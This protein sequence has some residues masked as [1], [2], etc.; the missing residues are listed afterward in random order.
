M[1][2]RIFIASV[3]LAAVS[4]LVIAPS[5]F[6]QRTPLTP[7]ERVANLEKAITL[8]PAQKTQLIKI[9]TDLAAAAAAGGGGRGGGE[10]SGDGGPGISSSGKQGI[11]LCPTGPGQLPLLEYK[12]GYR[13]HY[14]FQLRIGTFCTHQA[15]R[16][17]LS[18]AHCGSCI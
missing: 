11:D 8:T 10:I 4:F 14:Y 6:A 18:K 7:E 2:R 12:A 17:L 13:R 5:V 15:Q 16:Y 3:I 1:N 9:Y